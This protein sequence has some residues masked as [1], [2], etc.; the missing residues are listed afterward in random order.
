MKHIQEVTLKKAIAMLNAVGCKYHITIDGQEFGEP[1]TD[2]TKKY[3][4][5]GYRAVTNYIRNYLDNIEVGMAVEIPFDNFDHKD[6]RA[7]ISSYLVKHYG[8][9][10]CTTYTNLKNNTVEVL[11]IG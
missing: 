1:I 7:T 5:Y 3:A 2:K 11:R 4:K 6:L 10:S 9:G 8:K